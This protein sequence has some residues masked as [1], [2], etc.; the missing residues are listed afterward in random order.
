[1]ANP[2]T[3]TINDASNAWHVRFNDTLVARDVDQYLA[4]FR[5][6]CT[7][8]INNAIPTYSKLAL[9]AAYRRHVASFR[10]K[11]Y[12]IIDVFGDGQKSSCEVLYTFTCHDGST[13]GVQC[14]Y[15]VDLDEAG[16][17]RSIRIYGNGARVFKAFM[18]AND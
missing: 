18:H 12:E 14:S 3:T 10:A 5:D 13:E 8:Q 16:L 2:A 11:S 1:M 6:D 17:I 9:R 7:L 4:L 15:V